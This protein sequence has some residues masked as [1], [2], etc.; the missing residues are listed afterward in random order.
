MARDITLDVRY[1]SWCRYCLRRYDARLMPVRLDTA[2]YCHLLL[3]HYF[4][5]YLRW[6]L[7]YFHF[8][9]PSPLS[10]FAIIQPH[11][12]RALSLLSICHFFDTYAGHFQ[13]IFASFSSLI[14]TLT[15]LLWLMLSSASRRLSFFLAFFHWGFFFLISTS[16]HYAADTTAPFI[17]CHMM[18]IIIS[19]LLLLRHYLQRYCLF[20]HMPFTAAGCHWADAITLMR[21]HY[22][23]RDIYK[24]ISS[25][26]DVSLHFLYVIEFIA[27]HRVMPLNTNIF[28][29]HWVSYFR[30]F[31]QPV[32][33]T[34][35][36]YAPPRYGRW[37]FRLAY[38]CHWIAEPPLPLRWPHLR[39]WCH[40]DADADTPPDA[41]A[42]PWALYFRYFA[43][44]DAALRCCFRWCH[45]FRHTPCCYAM[46]RH[47]LIF[48]FR[49]AMPC[50]SWRRFISGR[51]ITLY[52]LAI[53]ATS[54]Q[55]HARA[56]T[57][58]CISR[59][60]AIDA[61]WRRCAARCCAPAAR[62]SGATPT[63]YR[64]S[65]HLRLDDNIRYAADI[66]RHQ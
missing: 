19:P 46:I 14:T 9:R 56:A 61:T 11:Y 54:C 10:S 3:R 39:I 27:S 23:D 24:N 57:R 25:H 58:H 41:A 55:L 22:T 30:V 20:S 49:D 65:R 44:D 60:Y 32:I 15:M 29:P 31:S 51:F 53:A 52:W 43:Y 50:Q 26:T 59:D 13:L 5:H 16:E 36:S 12:C 42:R 63:D 6:L 28:T 62:S 48:R 34:F 66:I 37:Y 21:R 18:A 2:Y 64:R 47:L 7:F 17:Y 35:R 33:A 1:F 45:A 40:A 38:G 8:R 4:R